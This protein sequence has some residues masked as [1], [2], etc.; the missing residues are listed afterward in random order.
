MINCYHWVLV[1][2]S[3]EDF[4][5]CTRERM[6]LLK[7]A[8]IEATSSG[9]VISDFTQ[10]DNPLIYVNHAFCEM[11]GYSQEEVINKNCRFLQAQDKDQPEIDKL[12]IA[13]KEHRDEKV[14]L[15]NY[16]KDGTVFW[17]ELIISPVKDDGGNVTNYIGIQTD[18][19]ERVNARFALKQKTL[20]LEQ[21][22]QDLEEFAN[23]VSHDLKEPLR[24]ISTFLEFLDT[25]YSD[26][27]DK[28][29]KEYI[30][31]AL[32]GSDR[33]KH[34]IEDLLDYSKVGAA[35]YTTTSVDLNKVIEEVLENLQLMIS[36]KSAVIES[37]KLPI[38]NGNEFQV[39]TLFQNLI[40][41]AIK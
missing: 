9:F 29:A 7:E 12:R 36:E 34:L 28:Q 5:N 35:H 2:P 23:A 13:I 8:A 10:A 19:T 11:T 41:N 21:S 26:K 30:D 39:V 18:V 22:N 6:L 14:L 24:M 27:L 3:L 15:K 25:E 16:K 20:E 32:K 1:F 31:Y 38:I 37:T 40:S 17:N 4:K 33:M